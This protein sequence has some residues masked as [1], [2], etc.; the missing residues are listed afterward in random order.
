V[1][2]LFQGGS[3]LANFGTKV[4][5]SLNGADLSFMNSVAGF[6][7]KSQVAQISYMILRIFMSK[8]RL[9]LEILSSLA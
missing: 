2:P 4:A 1:E 3:G 8:E 6:Y 9:S 5:P 7:L